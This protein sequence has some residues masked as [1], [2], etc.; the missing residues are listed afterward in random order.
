MSIL[1]YSLISLKPLKVSEI[2]LMISE[3]ENI[4]VL[5]YS[6]QSFFNQ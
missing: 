6:N 5:T 1:L 3:E 2:D 4:I